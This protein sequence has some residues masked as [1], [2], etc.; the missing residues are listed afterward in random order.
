M[1]SAVDDARSHPP[2]WLAPDASYLGADGGPAMD[3]DGIDRDALPGAHQAVVAQADL[4][5]RNGAQGPQV[6]PTVRQQAHERGC[7]QCRVQQGALVAPGALR[8]SL[9][10][11]MRRQEEREQEGALPGASQH[12]CAQRRQRHEDMHVDAQGQSREGEV[13][14][15]R[16]AHEGPAG[17]ERGRAEGG[18][19]PVGGGDGREEPVRRQEGPRGASGAQRVAQGVGHAQ[20]ARGRQGALQGAREGRLV[21]AVAVTVPVTVAVV[22]AM[23]VVMVV[24]VAVVMI[25]V[26][27]V[28]MVV[29]IAVRVPVP[30]CLAVSVGVT[31]ALVVVLVVMVVIVMHMI[32]SVAVLVGMPGPDAVQ[33][34]AVGGRAFTS[35]LAP[36]TARTRLRDGCVMKQSEQR[37]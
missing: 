23:V 21:M 9:L 29:V 7:G 12:D 4:V 22:M 8:E 17:R 26:F 37:V 18:S 34:G 13:H 15:G 5:R 3:H 35:P 1:K 16:D 14:D 36:R 32:V 11:R 33:R 30:S 25:A 24:M 10:D 6:R 2:P 31:P 28:V 27:V 19:G 20:N